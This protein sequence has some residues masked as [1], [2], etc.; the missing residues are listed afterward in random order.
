LKAGLKRI[1]ISYDIACKYNINF[2]RR[3]THRDWPLVTQRKLRDLKNIKI[4]WLIPKFHLAVHI[5]G[6]ADKFSFNWVKDVGRTYGENVESNW[7]SL[8]VL[9]TSVREMDS[10]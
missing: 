4:T 3:I 7:P 6:C 8:N 10:A 9:A 5:E 1:V 2:K